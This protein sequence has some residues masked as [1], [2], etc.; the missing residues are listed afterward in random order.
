MHLSQRFFLRDASADKSYAFR[1]GA[2]SKPPLYSNF[3]Q[4]RRGMS[5]I[6]LLIY[7]GSQIYI[8][9]Q[10]NSD[11]RDKVGHVPVV[12]CLISEVLEQQ[13]SYHGCP[14][15]TQFVI[16][17]LSSPLIPCSPLQISRRDWQYAI[18]QNNR[19][20]RCV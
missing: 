12:L 8:A 7:P 2:F 13:Y 5:P 17:W 1:K 16:R 14:D 19:A 18:W 10:V 9:H 4:F 3:S 20:M 11:E 6:F 15:L